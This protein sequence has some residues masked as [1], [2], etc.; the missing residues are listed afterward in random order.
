MSTASHTPTSTRPSTAAG[1][2]HL[3]AA[4][5][6]PLVSTQWLADHLG[7]DGL[8]VLDATVVP[9]TRADGAP[10]FISGLDRFLVDGHIPGS[11]FAD[12]VDVFS[13]PRG[14]HP[15]TRPD[16][17]A[18]EAAAGAVGVDA[19]TTVVV[20]DAAVGQWASRVWWLFRAFGFDRVAVLDGGLSKWRH[21]ERATDLGHVEPRGV[22]SSSAPFVATERPGAWVE[23]EFVSGVVDG[24][25]RATLVC[26]VPPKEFTGESGHRARLGHIPGSLSAPA[27][28][29]V[30]R[31]TN[32]FLPPAQLREA[33]AGALASDDTIVAYCNAGI[34]AASDALALALLG[35]T[36]VAIYDGSLNEW[37]ADA[38]AP[39]ATRLP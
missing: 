28:R 15:F 5:D 8:V 13:D 3:A 33:L 4:I 17:R 24:S 34:A 39:L 7:S 35:R 37:A 26:G 36:D 12:L 29:L 21:E 30:S 32:E 6:R 16:A 22:V 1:A 25:E 9:S 19:D 20:Y 23:K 31:A 10:T 18:F 38:E 27:G 11:V 14:S 2:S